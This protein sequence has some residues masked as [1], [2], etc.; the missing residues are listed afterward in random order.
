MTVMMSERCWCTSYTV[1]TTL[2]HLAGSLIG[3]THLPVP[4]PAPPRTS[5]TLCVGPDLSICIRP[6]HSIALGRGR[7][8]LRT[9]RVAVGR[10]DAA[11]AAVA[12]ILQ[13]QSGWGRVD[14]L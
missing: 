2:W 1:R 13:M 7:R 14:G 12:E 9:K 8:M 11:A 6:F 5:A 4:G 10:T 3:A